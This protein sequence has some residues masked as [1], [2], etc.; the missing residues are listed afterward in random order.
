MG[1]GQF[2][3]FYSHMTIADE[4]VMSIVVS[5]ILKQPFCRRCLASV[6][7]VYYVTLRVMILFLRRI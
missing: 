1:E 5:S 2:S 4:N 6:R 3:P 7:I